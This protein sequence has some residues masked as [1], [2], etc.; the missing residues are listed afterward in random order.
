METSLSQSPRFYLVTANCFVLCLAVVV[1]A[2]RP[3]LLEV[4]KSQAD[5][6]DDGSL[7]GR[8]FLL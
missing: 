5:A 2:V 6:T 3:V 8:A 7:D 4:I 1:V